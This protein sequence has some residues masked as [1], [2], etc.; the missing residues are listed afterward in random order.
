MAPESG[1]K[2]VVG[3][4]V[5][6]DVGDRLK[7]F[8][9]DFGIETSRAVEI[10]LD[11][12]LESLGYGDNPQAEQQT[13]IGR[14]AGAAATP[15]AV[16]GFVLAFSSSM[17]PDLAMY[18]ASVALAVSVVALLVE[19]VEPVLSNSLGVSKEKQHPDVM[20]DGGDD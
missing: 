14:S 3:T 13:A 1:P 8:Q 15:L 16:A 12:G 18:T 7:T 6:D 10:A 17:Q 4:R 5:G 20:T 11:N 9:D 19:R 2:K